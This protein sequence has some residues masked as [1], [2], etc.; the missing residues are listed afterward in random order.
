MCIKLDLESLKRISN[1]F[2]NLKGFDH[3]ILKLFAALHSTVLIIILA[4]CTTT[5]ENKATLILNVSSSFQAQTIL[6]EMDMTPVVYDITGA[7]PGGANFCFSDSHPPVIASNLE[8]GDWIITVNAKNAA[9]TVIARGE[10]ATNLYPDQSQTITIT[11]LPVEGYGTLD[12]T[13]NWSAADTYNPS[14]TAQLRSN[15]G[16]SIDLAFVIETEGKAT[17]TAN[18]IPTGFYT[19]MVQLLDDGILT[20][21]AVE[22][23]K[24]E[25][26]ATTQGQFDLYDINQ[27]DSKIKNDKINDIKVDADGNVIVVGYIEE[28]DSGKDWTT[29]SYAPD[30]TLNWSDQM[31]SKNGILEACAIDAADNTIYVVGSYEFT[32]GDKNW[33]IRKYYQSGPPNVEEW[34]IESATYGIGLMIGGSGQDSAYD[35]TVDSAGNVYV[36]GVVYDT[37]VSSGNEDWVI[38]AFNPDGSYK[39]HIQQGSRDGVLTGVAVDRNNPAET[40]D[41]IIITVGYYTN[42]ATAISGKDWLIRVYDQD[43]NGQ[44]SHPLWNAKI[45]GNGDDVPY[46]IAVDGDGNVVI[47]GTIDDTAGGS[48]LDWTTYSFSRSG[49]L[50][51]FS[52]MGSKDGVLKGVAIGPDNSVYVAGYYTNFVGSATGLDWLIR[53]YSQAGILNYENWKPVAQ[54]GTDDDVAMAVAVGNGK[55]YVA[56]YSVNLLTGLSGKDGWMLIYDAGASVTVP[57]EQITPFH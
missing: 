45:G 4:S 53:R 30:G 46:G 49:T 56:G 23:V 7:G 39:W 42:Y 44:T 33:L 11:V 36:V 29:Y 10:Q 52:Q 18:D 47:V 43:G 55:V 3:G 24:V 26:D 8:L 16:S 15:T 9:G 20:M 41:D 5:D 31:G 48:G 13:V 50:N 21:G 17:Y 25:K 37:A 19:L 27:I 2:N 22:V 57:R 38:Y 51:W 32:T 28:D 54:G 12:I 1:F 40:A 6:P 35:V 34:R 14:I